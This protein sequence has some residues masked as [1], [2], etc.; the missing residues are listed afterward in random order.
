VL[1]FICIDFAFPDP[2]WR[3]SHG[4]LVE[5]LSVVRASLAVLIVSFPG[6]LIMWHFLLREVRQDPQRARGGIRRWLGDLSL[7]VGGITLTGDAITLVYFLLEGQLTI[8]FVLKSA[9]LFVI[10]GGLVFYLAMTLRIE[11]Q[12]ETER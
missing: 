8:R 11:A 7:F 9:T 3:M 10:A 12:S 1:F 4:R 2:A 5:T 6:F